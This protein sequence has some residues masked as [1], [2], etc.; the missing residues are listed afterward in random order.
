VHQQ[1]NTADGRAA[2]PLCSLLLHVTPPP[3]PLRPATII[4]RTQSACA[5]PVP[6]PPPPLRWFL[7]RR[8]RTHQHTRAFSAVVPGFCCEVTRVTSKILYLL[9]SCLQA[10]RPFANYDILN[11]DVFC[12]GI[13]NTKIG[14]YAQS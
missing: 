2:D 3:G 5:D 6:P 11:N 10:L 13:T 7:S 9:S 8:D 1:F 12:S 14:H 4:S